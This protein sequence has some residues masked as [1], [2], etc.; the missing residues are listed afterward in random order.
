LPVDT[1]GLS[2]AHEGH[3]LR[4]SF[5]SGEIA[6]VRLVSVD[7]HEDCH[8][9]PGYAGIIYDLLE[10]N[11]PVRYEKNSPGTAYWS[12]FPEIEKWELVDER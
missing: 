3:T 5:F 11:Q 1:K 4:V 7:V 6:L 12:E 8:L 2:S 9:C 10:T